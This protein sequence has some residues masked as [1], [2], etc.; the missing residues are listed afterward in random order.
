MRLFVSFHPDPSSGRPWPLLAS[1]PESWQGALCLAAFVLCAAGLFGSGPTPAHAQQPLARFIEAAQKRGLDLRQA[2]AEMEQAN[3]QVQ[4][5]RGRLLP[6]ATATAFYQRNSPVVAVTVPT[7]RFDGAVPITQRALITPADQYGAQ[8]T[9][10]LPLIDLA[11]WSGLSAA[12]AAADAA[13]AD[14]AAASEETTIAVVELWYRLVGQRALAAA[15][16]RNLT[17]TEETRDVASAQVEVGVAG[18]L[19]LSRAEAELARARQS[20]AEAELAAVLSARAL[21]DLTGLAPDDS[22]PTI[23]MGTGD[24]EPPLADEELESARERPTVSAARARERAAKLTE[25][26]A[27]LA[28]FPA[29]GANG[30]A[31][32]NNAAGFGQK[33]A[34]YAGLN[35]SWTLDFIK[36]ARI[37]SEGAARAGAKVQSAR[38]KQVAETALFAAWHNVRASRVSLDAALAAQTASKRAA[39]DA[40]ARYQNGTATQLDLITAQR[41]AFQAEVFVIQAAASLH[42]ARSALAVRRGQPIP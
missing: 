40:Q 27:W 9:A 11:A 2:R 7:G 24:P 42:V 32:W 33:D 30:V 17:A 28:L 12:K 20:L 37:R 38:A 36:P 26:S 39:Q 5:A 29:L 35:A 4:Q 25:Q 8:G 18:P 3:A 15:A 1:A 19:E 23:E 14:V 41:D 10:A 21:S 6:S 13:D 16:R 22:Q 34:Y 31:R